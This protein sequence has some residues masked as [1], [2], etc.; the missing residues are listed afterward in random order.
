MYEFL[1]V[2]I[3]IV[4]GAVVI[5]GLS[6]LLWGL[7]KLCFPSKKTSDSNVHVEINVNLTDEPL[8]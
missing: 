8:K 3:S 2:V 4:W 1:R 5:G 6:Y 7:A